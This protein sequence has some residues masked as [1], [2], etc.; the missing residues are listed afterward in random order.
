M[1]INFTFKNFRSF[2]DQTQFSMERGGR[3]SEVSDVSA[4][5]GPNASGKS[6]LLGALR[7]VSDLVASSYSSGISSSGVRAD[8]FLLDGTSPDSP[9]EFFLEFVAADGLR[10]KYWFSA[11]S[12]TIIEENL[13]VYR[14]AQP[15]MLFERWTDGD[16]KQDARFGASVKGPKRQLWKLTRKNSLLLSSMAAGGV[17]ETDA[18]YAELSG[19]VAFCSAPLYSYETRAIK[20]SFERGDETSRAL[21]QLA[22]VADFGIDDIGT[23]KAPVDETAIQGLRA[24]Y[25][26]MGME[27]EEERESFVHDA[28]TELRFRHRGADGREVWLPQGRESEGTMAALSFFSVALRALSQGWL[29]LIDELDSSLHP[30]LVEEFVRLFSD[31]AS[32]PRHAQ[33][34]FTTHD[35]SLINK[36]GRDSRVLD[37]DQVWLVEKHADG[38]S[39]LFPVSEFSPRPDENLGRNYLNGVY[40]ALPRTGVAA[41]AARVVRGMTE[42]VEAN[43]EESR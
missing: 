17:A 43:G 9:S 16:G 25:S 42:E 39:E 40:G 31:E 21:V 33:L 5:Y 12:R 18:A 15:S 1:L 29:L 35:A 34:V 28:Q 22:R 37:K 8:P 2:R 30:S 27:D 20:Q 13:L 23:F 11:D 36:S 7:Y 32:N 38:A 19:R 3:G 24:A 6:N 41:I 4:I 14:S 10:Y 26:A